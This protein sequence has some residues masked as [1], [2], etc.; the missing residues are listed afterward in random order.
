MWLK[1][2][3]NGAVRSKFQVRSCPFQIFL[4]VILSKKEIHLVYFPIRER[5]VIF[6]LSFC[7]FYILSLSPCFFIVVSLS[8]LMQ[9]LGGTIRG[10]KSKIRAAKISKQQKNR[11]Q[12]CFS[13]SKKILICSKM[14]TTHSL[15]C[16]CVRAR[17]YCQGQDRHQ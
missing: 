8:G 1:A 10:I 14:L 4:N 16:S 7:A 5:F 6:Y 12:K 9:S 11:N 17:A 3:P 13:F 2:H 15:S